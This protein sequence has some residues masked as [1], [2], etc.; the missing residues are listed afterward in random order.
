V[1]ITAALAHHLK[2]LAPD[3]DVGDRLAADL[4]QLARQVTVAVPSCLSV[5]IGLVALG[6]EVTVSTLAPGRGSGR[7]LASL[8]VPLSAVQPGN[9]LILRAGEAGA[10][11]LL[12]DDLDSQLGPGHPP[13]EVDKHASAPET[14][15]DESL[16]AALTD[17]GAV[18]QA[19]GVLIDQGM[20]P[21]AAHR[22]LQRQ[23]DDADTTIGL[24]SRALLLSL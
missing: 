7:V 21:E 2:I 18:N 20:P 15:A 6:S 12:G 1:Q 5:S 17:V 3:P 24:T 9:T 13:I 8:A 22:H 19:I 11:L 4:N 14:P 10:F 16:T 23:A